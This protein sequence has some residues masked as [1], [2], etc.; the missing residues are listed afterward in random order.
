VTLI[1]PHLVLPARHEPANLGLPFGG[2]LTVPTECETPDQPS[3]KQVSMNTIASTIDRQ[4]LIDID[5]LAFSYEDGVPV[6]DGVN[7]K[8]EPGTVVGIVGPS[9][10]GKSTLL[11]LLAGFAS[12]SRGHVTWAAENPRDRHPVSM[13]FQADTLLPWLTVRENVA[14]HY[15]MLARGDRPDP[16]SQRSRVD[17]LIKMAGLT[18]AESKFPYQLSGGM[19]RRTAFLAAVTP[20]PRSLLLDEPFSSLDEPTRI[21]IHQ[22]VYE[23][24]KREHVTTLLI[25][26]DLAEA[27]S[28]SDRVIVM[29]AR[30]ARVFK[31]FDVP[32]GSERNMLSLR[33]E[34]EFLHLYGQVWEQLAAQIQQ[35]AITG[36]AK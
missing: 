36:G 4:P 20:G 6:L 9:G 14:L 32:F 25:T 1:H 35:S 15:R 29:T 24:L 8:V 19:R 28:L 11:S 7:L 26:H 23:V 12:A 27:L 3:V 22:D 5:D 13:M 33:E 21:S 16:A 2:D 17:Q 18:N 10:C 31:S 34:P 30:P